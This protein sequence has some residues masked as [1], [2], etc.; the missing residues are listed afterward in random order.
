MGL[1]YRGGVGWQ[2][3]LG[4]L[5]LV[6]LAGMGPG[7][8]ILWVKAIGQFFPALYSGSKRFF[9]TRADLRV[10]RV[11]PEMSKQ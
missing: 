7:A 1:C 9:I 6:A 11:L 3:C 8:D 10:L 4:D 2:I 5:A